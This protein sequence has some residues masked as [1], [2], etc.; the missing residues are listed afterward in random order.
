MSTAKRKPATGAKRKASAKKVTEEVKEDE[1]L[2]S[3]AETPEPD[4]SI[5]DAVDSVAESEDESPAENSGDAEEAEADAETPEPEP[6]AVE[7]EAAEVVAAKTYFEYSDLEQTPELARAIARTMLV[8]LKRGTF[9][10]I[11]PL[12]ARMTRDH[13]IGEDK[14]SIAIGEDGTGVIKRYPK[15][16]IFDQVQGKLSSVMIEWTE[17]R[18]KLNVQN[19][20][21]ERHEKSVAARETEGQRPE[22]VA[23][24]KAELQ[25][26]RDEQSRLADILAPIQ[27]RK[28]AAEAAMNEINDFGVEVYEFSIMGGLTKV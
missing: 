2:E 10:R 8:E 6:E 23:M 7:A 24:A 12:K 17:A 25:K 9:G 28:E 26:Q 21:V 14:I 1:Q 13:V 19:D 20:R 5:P 22:T 18:G 11:G 3:A 4:T 27:R 15:G 16:A